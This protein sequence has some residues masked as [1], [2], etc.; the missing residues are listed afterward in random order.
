M[1]K[2]RF[3]TLFVAIVMV[4]TLLTGCGAEITE[5]VDTITSTK[6]EV[7]SYVLFRTRDVQEYL[8]FLEN[9]DENN[10]EIIDIS[11]S[12]EQISNYT[13]NSEFY[14]VTYKKIAE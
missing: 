8:N 14:M 12:M 4:A 11:A 1:T 2:K 10:Y 3:I 9:L 5:T 13:G 7:G 6:I